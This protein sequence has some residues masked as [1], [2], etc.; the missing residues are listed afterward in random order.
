MYGSCT[1]NRFD[2][3]CASSSVYTFVCFAFIYLALCSVHILLKSK[4]TTRIYSLNLHFRKYNKWWCWWCNHLF[5]LDWTERKGLIWFDFLIPFVGSD[6]M[7]TWWGTPAEIEIIL[8]CFQ[9][10]FLTEL[11]LVFIQM[12]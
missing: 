8:N 11:P 1:H 3:N 2:D 5:C 6:D 12:R 10:I 7:P 9:M 4:Y